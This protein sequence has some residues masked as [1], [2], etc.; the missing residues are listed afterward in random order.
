MRKALLF[1]LAF[2]FMLS[3][4]AIAQNR[5]VSGTVTDAGD[6]SPLPGVNVVVK[7]TTTGTVT[8]IDGK[9]QLSVS[10]GVTLVFSYVGYLAKEVVVG[11]NTTINI[12][13]QV[14]SKTLDEVVVTGYASFTKEKSN[15]SSVTINAEKITNRPNPSV[16]QTLSGQV[17]GALIATG[18]GQPGAQST[19]RIRGTGSVNGSSD[20]LIVIDGIPTT[21]NFR[22]INPNEIKNITVL[23]DAGATAIYGNRG[24][25]GV[26][27]IETKTGG[28]DSPLEIT[29]TGQYITN[30]LQDNKYDLMNSQEQ[31]QL[32]RTYGDLIGETVGRGG[33]LTDAEIAAAPNFDWVDFFFSTGV[34][35][36]HNIQVS[37]GGK[38]SSAYF[39]LGYLDQEG[40][41][42]SS[43]L[44]RYNV[45]SNVSGRSADEK[46]TYAL[47][48]SVNYSLSDEPNSIG[49]GAINRN[50][51]L[52][53]YQSV[54]YI[55][56]DEYTGSVDLVDAFNAS[57]NPFQLTPLLLYDRL[58]TYTRNEKEIKALGSLSLSYQIIDGLTLT[59]RTSID[60][61]QENLLRAEPPISWNPI[62]FAENGNTTPGTQDQQNRQEF[63]YNQLTG[64]SYSKTFNEVHSFNVSAYNEVFSAQLNTF[65]FRQRGFDPRTFYPGDGSGF[66]PDNSANDWFVDEANANLAELRLLSFFGTLDYD[67][68]SRLGFG[69]TIRRDASS[70]FFGSNRWGTFY[71]VSGRWN[72][73]NESFLQN[74]AF[75]ILKIRG[76]YGTNG[77]QDITGNG[78]FSA[79]DL[80]R[81]LFTTGGGYGGANSLSL[82]QIP[83]NTVQWE[84]VGQANVGFDAELFDSKF[85]VIFDAYSK[86]TS[87]LFLNIPVSAIN[88]ATSISGNLGKLRN[89]GVELEMHYDVLRSQDPAGLNLT[90]DLVGAYN[91]EELLELPGGEEELIGTGRVGGKLFEYY[92]YRYAGVNPANGNLLYYTA[93]NE[94]T[95]QPDPDTDRVWLDQDVTPELQGSFGFNLDFKG[96]FLTTQFNYAV[97]AH[98]F[99][100]DLAGFQDATSIG[101][102]RSSR[103]LLRAWTPE[104]R[105]TDIPALNAGNIGFG[106]TRFLRNADFV[107]LRFVS[108]GYNLPQN[109]LNKL[110][111]RTGRVFVNGENVLTFTEWRGFDPEA[112]SNTS[113][114]Y[115]TPRTITLGV[116]L[117]F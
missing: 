33:T 15:I 27:V 77:N 8:D 71:S 57:N 51:I 73:H 76:S 9:Y 115:P 44:Q 42:Q 72:L 68:D 82:S 26:I 106:G 110:G 37:K 39:S 85:R 55:S 60:F 54:P 101:Q 46:F 103:D 105:F 98:R 53:A 70:R 81:P 95:E 66:I 28:F 113:R 34:G 20:P 96:F 21:A 45:R 65:G 87:D 24:A 13:L 94:L 31:L 63:T 88:S 107:R 16:I 116:E 99:D 109:V 86:T 91:K 64:V 3:G 12:N 89:S 35:V 5:T 90:L 29:Y 93:T 112:L 100:N 74:S 108:L 1:T 4:L 84:T 47:N 75:N 104:N 2:V 18:S 38:N 59:S 62:F 43:S 30:T 97:G 36:N 58:Q 56:P 52:G 10:D 61:E 78:Y 92:S 67:F 117:G 41:L 7:G 22:S 83:N 69:A 50:Y 48:L 19:I 49:S 14:D 102:F 11:S 17:A 114:L 23:K 32:E 6:S 80:Y 111:L 40:I 25:N 79:L